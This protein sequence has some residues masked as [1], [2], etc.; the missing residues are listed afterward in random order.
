MPGWLIGATEQSRLRGNEPNA[1]AIER[2]F[3]SL[4]LG[5]NLGGWV[6]SPRITR[7]L[8]AEGPLTGRGLFTRAVGLWVLPVGSTEDPVWV[9]GQVRDRLL[10]AL[11]TGTDTTDWTLR[12]VVAFDPVL[13]GS[14]SWWRTGGAANSLTR[15]EGM[16]QV[17]MRLAP[18]NATGPNGPMQG[19]T[20]VDAGGAALDATREAI[21]GAA[22]T[23]GQTAAG[24][25]EQAAPYLLLGGVVLLGVMASGR[26]AKREVEEFAFN[27]APRRRAAERDEYDEPETVLW[28]PHPLVWDQVPPGTEYACPSP[29]LGRTTRKGQFVKACATPL[30]LTEDDRRRAVKRPPIRERAYV[31]AQGGKGGRETLER[32]TAVREQLRAPRGAPVK[33]FAAESGM[34]ARRLDRHQQ[35]EYALHEWMP[36]PTG[37]P[38]PARKG[39]SVCLPDADLWA[40]LEEAATERKAMLVDALGREPTRR[41]LIDEMEAD[42]LYQRAAKAEKSCIKLWK[43]REERAVPKQALDSPARVAARRAAEAK[44]LGID[45]GDAEYVDT[46]RGG[47]GPKGKRRKLT[48]HR[49]STAGYANP[50]KP[51]WCP[52]G[53]THPRVLVVTPAELRAYRAGEGEGSDLGVLADIAA[54]CRDEPVTVRT[55]SGAHVLTAEPVRGIRVVH[56][57]KPA[58]GCIGCKNPTVIVPRRRRTVAV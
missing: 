13:N 25:F 23:A 48:A 6:G 46:S 39:S 29:L 37:L 5:S 15:N 33:S 19:S 53:V 36:G 54:T 43:E 58:G 52:P 26:A 47:E 8:M 42:P 17:A 14:V 49:S 31:L 35:Q 55:T 12:P 24:W 22:R 56:G 57:E 4:T 38:F 34:T 50:S 9:Q 41:E 44:R 18:E 10:E 21:T 28:N 16:L 30:K 2:A 27:P 45:L 40:S 51:L 20:V 1:D 3:A 7:D 32:G 11:N